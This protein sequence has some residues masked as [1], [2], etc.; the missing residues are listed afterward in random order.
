MSVAGSL[1]LAAVRLHP[2]ECWLPSGRGHRWR[3]PAALLG[4]SALLLL[5]L[6]AAVR[7]GMPYDFRIFRRAGVAVLDHR[8]PYPH[9]PLTDAVRHHHPFV[10]PLPAAWLFAPFALLGFWTGAWL[11][12]GLS[13]AAFLT[14]TWC[15]GV[16]SI[17]A[18][19]LV[20]TSSVVVA[21]LGYG[22]IDAVLYL[23]IAALVRFRHRPG[24][25]ATVFVLLVLLKP[26]MLPL[27]V[28]VLATGRLRAL[29]AMVVAG[30]VAAVGSLAIG[31]S[32]VGYVHLLQQ[33]SEA[34]APQSRGV[35]ERV[36][37][38]AGWSLGTATAVVS[39]IGGALLLAT[40]IT[41]LRGRIDHRVVLAVAVGSAL[42]VSPIVWS[43][44]AALCWA[45]LLLLRRTT[46][47][48][49]VA[50]LASWLLFPAPLHNLRLPGPVE[51]RWDD[52]AAAAVPIATMLV[53]AL[54]TLGSRRRGR[55]L[56]V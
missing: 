10:Y 22:T 16:R 45:P 7:G 11:F 46:L 51:W 38:D 8:A 41:G 40:L 49:A 13:I 25:S 32:A 56:H 53:V 50:W 6:W 24:L 48:A 12:A 29:A 18:F 17:P 9:L 20:M 14:G 19:L 34:E 39:V 26:L 36:V 35:I 28:Y 42:V 31:F 2:L 21:S 55:S 4:A 44:Y 15:L 30:V 1:A 54:A 3:R 33:L 43:H 52:A 5:V 23:G 27:A 37:I 47:V